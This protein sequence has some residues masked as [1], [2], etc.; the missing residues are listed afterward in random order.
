[1][2]SRARG[3]GPSGFSLEASLIAPAMWSSR[4]SSST[5]L[6]GTYGSSDRISDLT[7]S[8]V[9]VAIEVLTRIHEGCLAVYHLGGWIRRREA[10]QDAMQKGRGLELPQRLEEGRIPVMAPELEQE[11]MLPGPPA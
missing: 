5:G 6:P 2:A 7:G 8:T 9:R 3:D 1:M 10:S 4:S 11:E